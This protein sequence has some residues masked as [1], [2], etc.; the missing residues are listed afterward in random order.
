MG[1]S[2]DSRTLLPHHKAYQEPSFYPQ[3]KLAIALLRFL[4]EILHVHT[5]RNA[6]D[7]TKN[8][9]ILALMASPS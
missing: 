3:K 6:E 7:F 9:G 2:F 1:D 5:G 8:S 4:S